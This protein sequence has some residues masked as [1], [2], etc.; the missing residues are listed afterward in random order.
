MENEQAKLR[1][2]RADMQNIVAENDLDTE[3]SANKPMEIF[4]IH[5][6]KV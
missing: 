6:E 3:F 1:M 5:G 2:L 4:C